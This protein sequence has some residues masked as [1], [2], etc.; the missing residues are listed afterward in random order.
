ML[1]TDQGERVIVEALSHLDDETFV[2]SVRTRAIAFTIGKSLGLS[3][4]E[5][6]QL[7]LGALLHDIGKLFI[8][9]DILH[10]KTALTTGEWLVLETHPELGVQV[11]RKAGCPMEVERIVLEHH[12]WANGKGGY[13]KTSEAPPTLLTQIVTVADV[14]DAMTSHR[15]YRPAQSVESALEFIYANSGERFNS[16]VV[17]CVKHTEEAIKTLISQK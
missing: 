3:A 5:L 11:V 10:K 6:R 8:P 1:V 13:P 17:G 9:V 15:S 12:K 7:A 16:A 4:L 2:H 14:L